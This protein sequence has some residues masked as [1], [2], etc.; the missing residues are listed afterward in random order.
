MRRLQMCINT[1]NVS[2]FSKVRLLCSGIALLLWLFAAPVLAQNIDTPDTEAPAASHAHTSPQTAASANA[3]DSSNLAFPAHSTLGMANTASSA[4]VVPAALALLTLLAATDIVARTGRRSN[5]TLTSTAEQTETNRPNRPTRTPLQQLVATLPTHDTD[6]LITTPTNAVPVTPFQGIQTAHIDGHPYE[7]EIVAGQVLHNG[8]MFFTL[9]NP[10]GAPLPTTP[11]EQL[12]LHAGNRSWD[13]PHNDQV[14]IGKSTY[15]VQ[16]QVYESD[17]Q[18][19]SAELTPVV[20]TPVEEEGRDYPAAD[21]TG[22]VTIERSSQLAS[23]VYDGYNEGERGP[24]SIIPGTLDPG[25]GS[26]AED[27]YIVTLSGTEFVEGQP[28]GIVN[29]LMIGT[30]D[31]NFY[32]WE[33]RDVIREHIPPGSTI[34]LAGHSLGGMVAQSLAG[35]PTLK[36]EYDIRNTVAFGSPYIQF[37]PYEGEVQRLADSTDPVPFLSLD[38]LLRPDIQIFGR[39]VEDS[40][41]FF[42]DAHRHSY[43]DAEVWKDYDAVGIED[44]TATIRYNPAQRTFHKVYTPWT[45]EEEE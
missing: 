34:I 44:G 16:T 1:Q 29:D 26:P 31:T 40:E 14:Q 23:L 5:V 13:M 41:Y 2:L 38:G 10:S 25:D 18:Y 7:L 35:S 4:P 19:A 3:T 20:E 12:T 39:E 37:T 6:T 27:V 30:V 22:E 11:I 42:V 24:V 32:A 15:R 9:H 33:V 17:P 21:V 36:E 28:T 45:S 8:N 43:T